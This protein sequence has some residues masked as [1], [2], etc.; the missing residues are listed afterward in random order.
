MKPAPTSDIKGD[1]GF[2]LTEVLI[3]LTITSLIAVTLIGA[4][5]WGGRALRVTGTADEAARV[6]AVQNVMRDMLS[7]TKREFEINSNGEREAVFKGEPDK[8]T[9]VGPPPAN[10]MVPGFYRS[11]ISVQPQNGNSRDLTLKTILF[12]TKIKAERRDPFEGIEDYTLLRSV[13]SLEFQYYGSLEDEEIAEW[14]SEWLGQSTMP[15]LI[16]MK[17]NFKAQDNRR[18]TELTIMRRE[19]VWRY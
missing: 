7:Q 10:V 1:S 9:F 16:R 18:W 19:K 4:L 14:H 17:V 13:N 8:I 15:E 2:T 11:F 5:Q 3:A 6:A 12:R